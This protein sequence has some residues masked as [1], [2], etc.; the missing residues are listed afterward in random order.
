MEEVGVEVATIFVAA[1]DDG[2]IEAPGL[3]GAGEVVV[4]ELSPLHHKHRELLRVVALISDNKIFNYLI[5]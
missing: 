3:G 2:L 5:N 4:Y 1:L